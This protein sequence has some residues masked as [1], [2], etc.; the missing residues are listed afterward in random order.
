MTK[1][2]K[3]TTLHTAE[4]TSREAIM[5]A[6]EAVQTFGKKVIAVDADIVWAVRN[7]FAGSPRDTAAAKLG[8]RAA[9]CVGAGEVRA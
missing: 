8:R 1:F 3:K 2:P 9:P 4:R 7:N 6:V 5:P